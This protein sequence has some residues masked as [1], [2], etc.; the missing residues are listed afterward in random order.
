M[1]QRILLAVLTSLCL[2][3]YIPA[4]DVDA[5][6]RGK[7]ALETRAFTPAPWSFAAYENAW[8]QW[9][10][11]LDKAPDNYDQAFRAHYGLHAAPFENGRYPMG[12]RQD[13]FLFAK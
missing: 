9:L 1:P 2:A 10:P 4:Q 11:K 3:A 6:A 12:L 13:Q 5:I 7:K 8:K